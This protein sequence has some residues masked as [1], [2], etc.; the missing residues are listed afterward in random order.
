MHQF[1][2]AAAVTLFIVHK[3]ELGNAAGATVNLFSLKLS[4]HVRFSIHKL[5]LMLLIFRYVKSQ[6]P[7]ST[8]NL[9]ALTS[10]CFH[11]CLT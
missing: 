11:P 5:L 2:F 3:L 6:S 10:Q 4:R 1:G 9:D 8:T 7:V